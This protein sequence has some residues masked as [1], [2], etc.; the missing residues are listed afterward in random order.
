MDLLVEVVNKA[1]V[2]K[3]MTSIVIILYY[4][5]IY[6]ITIRL[7]TQINAKEGIKCQTNSGCGDFTIDDRLFIGELSGPQNWATWKF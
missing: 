7:W 1:L 5:I 4:Y 2:T 3:A 6:Y